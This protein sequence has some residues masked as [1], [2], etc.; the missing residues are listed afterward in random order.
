MA[1]VKTPFKD[2]VQKTV[3]KDPSGHCTYLDGDINDWELVIGVDVEG[4]PKDLLSD[5][6]K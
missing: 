4:A 2:A 1:V 3:S 5:L 6:G